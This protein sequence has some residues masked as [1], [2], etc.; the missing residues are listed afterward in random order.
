[1]VIAELVALAGLAIDLA[2]AEAAILAVAAVV[3]G[4]TAIGR[5]PGRD[6]WSAALLAMGAV[7][8]LAAYHSGTRPHLHPLYS[9]MG[10]G[11]RGAGRYA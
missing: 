8:L 1:M 11:G 10:R 6:S 4:L 3:A 2:G 7:G 9:A 5:T